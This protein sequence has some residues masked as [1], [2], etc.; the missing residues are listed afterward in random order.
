MRVNGDE[1]RAARLAA[2]GE[3]I[4]YDLGGKVFT[5]APEIPLD[6]LLGYPHTP[7]FDEFRL[8]MWLAAHTLVD[9][10]CDTACAYEDDKGLSCPGVLAL[11]D[12]L[13][14]LKVDG[15]RLTPDDVVEMW[16]QVRDAHAVSEGES[17]T[18]PD[19][20]EPGGVDSNPTA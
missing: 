15:E 12:D 18:S 1:A 11:A 9:P 7:Y 10:K 16:S 20:S 6:V 17:Q 3:P 13:R 2:R 5:F 19:S 8:A 14:G 4:E